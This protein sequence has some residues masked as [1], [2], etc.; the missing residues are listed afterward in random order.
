MSLNPD[1]VAADT[2]YAM[3][4]GGK[5]VRTKTSLPVLCPASEQIVGYGPD[6]AREDLDAAVAAARAASPAWAALSFEERRAAIDA[7]AAAVE[8]DADALARLL[9]QEQGK[10]L[11][12]AKM[13]VANAIRSMRAIARIEI[14]P[15]V[16]RETPSERIEL[17]FRPLGVVAGI[18]AWNVPIILAAQK[19][20]QALYTGNTMVLKPSPYTP[21]STLRLGEL[22]RGI[23]P[24]G[25]LNVVSGGNDL[26]AWMTSHPGV[27]KISFTGSGPT[28]EKVMQSA[29]CGF[30]RVTLE[31][32]GNDAAI[33]L[34]DAD[35]A[36]VTPKIFASAFNNSGQI[37]MAIKRIYVHSSL[38]DAVVDGLAKLAKAT[39]VGDGMD[40]ATTHGPIQN[41][42][43]FDKVIELLEDTRKVPGARIVAGGEVPDRP[44]YFLTPTVVADISD[45]ARLVDEEPFG[46]IVPVIRYDDVEEVIERANA[47]PYGLSGSIWTSDV[48]R[49]L[50][51]AA[52]LDVGTAW[53]NRHGGADGAIPFGGAKTSGIGREHGLHGLQHY[54]EAQVVHVVR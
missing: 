15:E 51:L 43:Q 48:E 46:P 39:V 35:P 17:R 22:S 38:Y 33:I 18:T 34:P 6:A 50:E 45:G 36:E 29:A 5:A 24:D 28:G 27:A 23:L 13:E 19:I 40:P 53:V 37:C 30:K 12:R 8:A 31:L 26:G 44:G 25:V 3:T 4:I 14:A 1:Q 16:L 52:R 49:G 2:P 41:K 32:G 21:L 47:S 54:M 10:P 42:A 20:G 11:G 9:T 7:F